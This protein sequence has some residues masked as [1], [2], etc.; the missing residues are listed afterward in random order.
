[1]MSVCKECHGDIGGCTCDEQEKIIQLQAELE[2][3]KA[4]M[5]LKGYSLTYKQQAAEIER[6]REA[7]RKIADEEQCDLWHCDGDRS[8][9]VCCGNERCYIFIAEQALK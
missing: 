5:E 6:L 2:Q 3:V 9:S 8:E 1:M 4:D 7:L